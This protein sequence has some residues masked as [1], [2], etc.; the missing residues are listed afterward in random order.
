MGGLE[1]TDHIKRLKLLRTVSWSKYSRKKVIWAKLALL[2]GYAEKFTLVHHF[3]P[4]SVHCTTFSQDLWLCVRLP[5]ILASFPTY[6]QVYSHKY[7]HT[8]KYFHKHKYFHTH[9]YF[10]KH[11]YFHTQ[12]IAIH[13]NISTHTK[14]IQVKSKTDSYLT[15]FLNFWYSIYK[16]WFMKTLQLSLVTWSSIL[17]ADITQRKC[18]RNILNGLR[19]TSNMFFH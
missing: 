7:F 11:K 10:H 3:T 14:K 12:S 8:H 19:L 16:S 1:P 6:R 4:V 13:K 17:Y 9:K 2:R 15:K 5:G 18:K